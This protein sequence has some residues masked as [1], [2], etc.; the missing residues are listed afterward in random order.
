MTPIVVASPGRAAV[1]RAAPPPGPATP[2]AP[3]ALGSP[4]V[5][6]LAPQTEPDGIRQPGRRV[7]RRADRVDGDERGDGRARRRAPTLRRA[8]AALEAARLRPRAGAD[9]ALLHG[10]PSTP[11]RMPPCR[12][13]ARGR[14]PHV[15]PRPEVEEDRG[16][17]RSGRPGRAR[18]SASRC[19]S[20]S[21]ART[22]P[23][24]AASPKRGPAAEH[25][26]VDPVDEVAGVEQVGLA[27]A[28]TAAAH[29]DARR[30]RRRGGRATTVVAGQPARLAAGRVADPQAGDV[31]EG[32][33]RAGLE[34]HATQARPSLA[35]ISDVGLRR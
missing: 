10:G 12:P 4:H 1:S 13:R 15:P 34:G 18:R 26:G 2:R 30:P 19:P 22:M 25:D 33:R 14:W 35:P 24:A 23:S 5:V 11:R 17:A 27:R 16:R 3:P 20:A 29:V 6:E 32:V 7:D 8:D 31:G 28:R 9:A 21:S